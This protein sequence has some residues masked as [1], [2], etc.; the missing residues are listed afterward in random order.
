MKI[1]GIFSPF[2]ATTPRIMIEAVCM[3]IDI[4]PKRY[5]A[6]ILFVEDRINGENLFMGK[7]KN[8]VPVIL[9]VIQQTGAPLH[10][11]SEQLLQS[12]GVSWNVSDFALP[13]FLSF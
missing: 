4:N 13:S 1:G 5:D 3:V 9:Q 10:T 2:D 8:P 12:T 7:N 11:N 6:I